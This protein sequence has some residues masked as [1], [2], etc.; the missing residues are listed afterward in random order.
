[1]GRTGYTRILKTIR[2]TALFLSDRISKMGPFELV[3]DGSQ[4]PA[5]AFK[6]KN[7]PAEAAFALSERLREH[8]WQVPA[9]TMPPDAQTVSVL[10]IVVREGLSRDM[11]DHF[12][13]DLHRALGS[14][15]GK[16]SAHH[17]R[18][19]TRFYH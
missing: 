16:P 6:L 13:A 8:G 5:F 15:E 2:E 7:F 18:R 3:S 1:L 19:S 17:G 4:V 12:L 10:R 9:Y 11:A 14:W